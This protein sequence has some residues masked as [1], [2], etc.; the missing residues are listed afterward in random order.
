VDIFYP[1]YL[2]RRL[3]RHCAL[4]IR[5]EQSNRVVRLHIHFQHAWNSAD[6]LFV[7]VPEERKTCESG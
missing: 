2:G 4:E 3:E 1:D 5:E 7:M 6:N